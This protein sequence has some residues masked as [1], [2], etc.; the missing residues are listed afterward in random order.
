MDID[1]E[2]VDKVRF[3]IYNQTQVYDLQSKVAPQCVQEC[4]GRNLGE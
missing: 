3:Q 2:Q 4:M 1:S